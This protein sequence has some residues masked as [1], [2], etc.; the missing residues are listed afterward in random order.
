MFLAADFPATEFS[1]KLVARAKFSFGVGA[2][3]A[4]AALVAG[5]SLF[6]VFRNR[7]PLTL[8]RW[9]DLAPPYAVGV[10]SVSLLLQFLLS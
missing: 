9:L 10:M 7:F 4:Q 5:M 2:L 8:R 1:A 6:F 3:L